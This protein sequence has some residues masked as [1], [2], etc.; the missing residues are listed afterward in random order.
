MVITK[1]ATELVE[2][3]KPFVMVALTVIAPVVV[4]FNIFPL[5]DPPT[6]PEPYGRD[7]TIALFVALAGKTVPARYR[8]VPAGVVFGDASAMLV[9]GTNVSVSV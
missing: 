8:G 6:S 4:V 2:A 1:S 5:R 9:T 3:A 7:H